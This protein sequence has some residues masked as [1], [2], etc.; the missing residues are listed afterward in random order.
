MSKAA[1]ALVPTRSHHTIEI[2][3]LWIIWAHTR[4]RLISLISMMEYVII[5]KNPVWALYVKPAQCTMH[6]P[7]CMYQVLSPM[8]SHLPSWPCARCSTFILEYT[9]C[10][11][12]GFK[13]EKSFVFFYT[14]L[15]VCCILSLHLYSPFSIETPSSVRFCSAP[16]YHQSHAPVSPAHPLCCCVK[17]QILIQISCASPVLVL[18]RSLCWLMKSGPGTWHGHVEGPELP[19]GSVC[20]NVALWLE[21][22][23]LGWTSTVRR[24]GGM[25]DCNPPRPPLFKPF[26][27]TLSVKGGSPQDFTVMCSLCKTW[28]RTFSYSAVVFKIG[29]YLELND[30]LNS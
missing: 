14:V 29:N 15:L 19:V 21:E 28:Q 11:V 20:R 1:C 7:L 25:R 17:N 18:Y 9:H 27:V 30:Y 26:V 3:H 13:D 4:P 2:T 12:Q 16:L 22:A 6:F 24:A 5:E 23:R 8:L 10:N